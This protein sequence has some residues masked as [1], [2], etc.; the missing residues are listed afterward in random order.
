MILFL[1][2]VNC[3]HIRVVRW[4]LNE[5]VQAIVAAFVGCSGW[6]ERMMKADW[7]YAY[8]RRA[9]TGMIKH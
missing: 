1:R 6:W 8:T 2:A 4:N 5:G 3:W 7:T 9:V